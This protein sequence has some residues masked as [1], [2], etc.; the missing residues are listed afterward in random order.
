L[1]FFAQTTT[2]FRKNFTITLV[3]EKKAFFRRKLAKTAENSVYNLDPWDVM[4]WQQFL[5]LFTPAKERHRAQAADEATERRK[6]IRPD[7]RK[8]EITT[9]TVGSSP[10]RVPEFF[11]RGPML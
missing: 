2:R 3:F 9:W 1:A 4:I 11:N 6:C 8:A 10:A 5:E 7:R